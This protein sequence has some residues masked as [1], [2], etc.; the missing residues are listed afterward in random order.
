MI[1]SALEFRKKAND[2]F[3]AGISAVFVVYVVILVK[4]ERIA[5]IDLVE[6]WLQGDNLSG[7]RWFIWLTPF[8]QSK[9]EM[10]TGVILEDTASF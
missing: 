4:E 6:L 7:G 10:A 8:V 2:R 5:L 1:P 3:P 9:E